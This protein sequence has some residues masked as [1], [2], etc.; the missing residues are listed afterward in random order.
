VLIHVWSNFIGIYLYATKNRL[1]RAAFLNS[2][3]VLVSQHEALKN[4]AELE[5]L[6][7]ATCPSHSLQMALN[8]LCKNKPTMTSVHIEKYDEVT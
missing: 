6:L 3:N 4:Q 5:T 8:Y 1:A 2:R 7:T